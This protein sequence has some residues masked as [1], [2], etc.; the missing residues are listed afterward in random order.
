MFI[1]VIFVYKSSFLFAFIML[2]F[3]SFEKES[4]FEWLLYVPRGIEW[5]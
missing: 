3:C 1:S 2:I 5:I 4:R